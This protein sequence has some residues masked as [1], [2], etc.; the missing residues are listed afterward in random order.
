MYV[1]SEK[2]AILKWAQSAQLWFVYTGLWLV[3]EFPLLSAFENS[4]WKTK[5][6]PLITG[7]YK[8]N[9][10][11]KFWYLR[12]SLYKTVTIYKM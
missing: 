11:A 8:K 9:A 2:S 1:N 10:N 7:C 6:N 12:L 3:F 4:V 5:R